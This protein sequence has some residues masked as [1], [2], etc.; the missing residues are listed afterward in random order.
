MRQIRI[1]DENYMALEQKLA[2]AIDR[3]QEEIKNVKKSITEQ[4]SG[5]IALTESEEF[6]KAPEFI[7]FKNNEK[8]A[9]YV[10]GSEIQKNAIESVKKLRGMSDLSLDD[11]AAL[12]AFTNELNKVEPEDEVEEVATFFGG[13][14]N[15]DIP[16]SESNE[17]QVEVSDEGIKHGI[18]QLGQ[19]PGK[20]DLAVKDFQEAVK[21]NNLEKLN[22]SLQTLAV[23]DEFASIL[24]NDSYIDEINE[25]AL[26]FVLWAGAS[27]MFLTF[28][29]L[30]NNIQNKKNFIDGA[31][32]GS[33]FKNGESP[34]LKNP[35]IQIGSALKVI[36]SKGTPEEK[37]AASEFSKYAK[38]NVV[39]GKAYKG[40]DGEMYMFEKPKDIKILKTYSATGLKKDKVDGFY[41]R[42]KKIDNAY[43][44][45]MNE[46]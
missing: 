14:D 12:S 41:S 35:G 37:E 7:N 39:N 20:V 34:S 32:R 3:A 44:R 29:T 24:A 33:Q 27:I 30:F 40:E 17:F 26:G 38:E 36:N 42:M 45:I 46:K 28:S 10:Q 2:L 13:K 11:S 9:S 18:S 1:L 25:S 22:S 43:S 31:F 8:I 4:V 6:S 16:D 19:I 23:L 5:F 15:I 21:T